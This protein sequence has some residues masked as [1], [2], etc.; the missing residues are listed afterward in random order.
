MRY[1]PFVPFTSV[2]RAAVGALA[3][4]VAAC[5]DGTAIPTS[6]SAVTASADSTH[7]AGDAVSGP[8]AARSGN[9]AILKECSQY[10]GTNGTFCT[11]A[12][13]NVRAIEAGSRVV[14]ATVDGFGDVDS[15]VTLDLPGPG[16]NRAFG[17]CTLNADVQRCEFTG[18]TGKFQHF[19]ARIDVTYV[20]GVEYEWNG[21]YAFSPHEN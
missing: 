20:G 4:S 3:L 5:S 8:T 2:G 12:S 13:S 1:Q 16:N 15:D 9:L 18:G 17:H 6:P 10:D 11:I 14:Y 21:T 7:V 19:T